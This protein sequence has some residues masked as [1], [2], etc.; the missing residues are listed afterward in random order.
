V[1]RALQFVLVVYLRKW[2]SFYTAQ[3]GAEQDKIARALADSSEA[4]ERIGK[5]FHDTTARLI[6]TNSFTLVGDKVHGVDVV[7]DVLRVVPVAWVAADV[8]SR[9][10]ICLWFPSCLLYMIQAGIRLKTKEHPHG[11]YTAS[12]LFD[13]LS[14][15][16]SSALCFDITS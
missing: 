8:V 7:R 1:R 10:Y 6:K 14:D 15:I 2:S 9:L 13:M 16:Y 4:S 11:T 3:G 12:E 5:Y